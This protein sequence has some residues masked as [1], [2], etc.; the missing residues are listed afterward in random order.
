LLTLPAGSPAGPRIEAGHIKVEGDA[1]L[2]VALAEMIEPLVPN[3]PI[4][5]P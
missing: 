5:K 1:A 4:V 3:F 2:Y